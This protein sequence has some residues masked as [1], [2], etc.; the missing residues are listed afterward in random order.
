MSALSQII[1]KVIG[2]HE[3]STSANLIPTPQPTLQNSPLEVYSS[4]EILPSMRN[5]SRQADGAPE[6]Q[7]PDLKAQLTALERSRSQDLDWRHSMV[8]FLRLLDVDSS[9][10]ARESLA[11]ELEY[12]GDFDDEA[13]LDSWLHRHV[14][15]E[16]SK[17]GA[18]VP[19][20]LLA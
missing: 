14:M 8:D 16:L 7:A 9:L 17:R 19:E 18:N 4:D 3:T 12:P 1:Q 5:I 6:Q 13:A 2:D 10:E 15:L 20:E 11:R